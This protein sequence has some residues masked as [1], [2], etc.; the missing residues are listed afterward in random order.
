MKRIIMDNTGIPNEMVFAQFAY[1]LRI[2]IW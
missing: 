1:V 2:G